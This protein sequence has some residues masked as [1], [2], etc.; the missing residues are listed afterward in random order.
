[1]LARKYGYTTEYFRHI[2]RNVKHSPQGDEQVIPQGLFLYS[3]DCSNFNRPDLKS[4]GNRGDAPAPEIRSQGQGF[5]YD[6]NNRAE[7]TPFARIP[8]VQFEYVASA[9]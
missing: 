3:S 6:N 7:S 8:T 9:F 2:N 5:Y 4:F 1:M